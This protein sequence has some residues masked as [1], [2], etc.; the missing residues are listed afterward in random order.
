MDTNLE[1]YPEIV[2]ISGTLINSSKITPVIFMSDN[3]FRRKEIDNLPGGPSVKFETI[4]YDFDSLTEK[5]KEFELKYKISTLDIF[6]QYTKGKL[7][8]DLEEW[9]DMFLLYLG[10]LEIRTVSCP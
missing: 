6:S 1:R 10:T 7:T 2:K 3:T 9:L 5:L 4:E 8:V